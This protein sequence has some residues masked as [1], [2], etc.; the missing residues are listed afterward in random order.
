MVKEE[1]II[2]SISFVQTVMVKDYLELI[3]DFKEFWDDKATHYNY[4]YPKINYI[5]FNYKILSDEFKIDKSQ[6]NK[7]HTEVREN[8]SNKIK[9]FNI[10]YKVNKYKNKFIILNILVYFFNN[11]YYYK[12]FIIFTLKNF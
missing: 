4:D 2:R 6:F 9:G 5:L 10:K 7:L 3:D 12:F 1:K 8:N 11:S